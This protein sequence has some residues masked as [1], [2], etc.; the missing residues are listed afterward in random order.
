M[1]VTI[2]II[3]TI[4]ENKSHVPNHQPVYYHIFAIVTVV[5]P[6]IYQDPNPQIT[7]SENMVYPKI[8]GLIFIIFPSKIAIY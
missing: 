4:G 6:K 3:P 5:I 8:H 2:I 1:K 7:W